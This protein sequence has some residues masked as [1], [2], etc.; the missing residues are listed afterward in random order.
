M[1]KLTFL[2]IAEKVLSDSEQA[3]SPEEI[4][5]MAQSKG[6]DMQIVSH[7][8]T[9]WRSIGAQLYVEVRDNPNGRFATTNTRPKRFFIRGTAPTKVAVEILAPSKP[10]FLEKELHPFLVYFGHFYMKAHIKTIHAQK[11]SKMSL[12]EWVHPD[13]VGCYFSF[14]EWQNEVVDVSTRLGHA[15]IR[16][17]SFEIKRQ[18]DFGNLRESFFQ[19]VSN[20]SWA[21]EGYLV[22]AQISDDE[23]FAAEVKRLSAA[24]GIGIIKLDIEDPDSSTI[25]L[26]AKQKE[27]VDWETVNKL[28]LNPDFSK[29]LKRV[30]NDF[31]IREVRKEEYDEV[32]TREAILATFKTPSKI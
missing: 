24:F 15:A 27:E 9:P 7:G 20:S 23:D 13:A 28:T 17:Y 32:G 12:G 26:P 16:L 4:W 3:M 25:L 21:N 29:F 6:Y 8:K 10:H 19:A 5:T 22:A 14:Q 11:S 2:Q 31:K 18:L 1:S 30:D